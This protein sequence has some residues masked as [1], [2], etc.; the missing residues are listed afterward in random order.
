[1]RRATSAA[2]RHRAIRA[3]A[4]QEAGHRR[5]GRYRRVPLKNQLK[6]LVFGLLGKDP[7]AVVVSF[8]SGPPDLSRRMAAEVR[9]LEPE[10]RHFLV[11]LE[12]L[13]PG[14]PWRMYP[15]LRRRFAGLR[16]GLAPVLFTGEPL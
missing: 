8:A 12:E 10:R 14:P 11:R 2:R 6:K 9:E 4:G 5:R 13:K 3:E 16:I 15:Q 7:E 1:M